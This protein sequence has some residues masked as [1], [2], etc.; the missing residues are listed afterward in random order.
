[1]RMPNRRKKSFRKSALLVSRQPRKLRLQPQPPRQ[2][3]RSLV[4]KH[5]AFLCAG[6]NAGPAK[7]QKAREQGTVILT[8]EDFEHLLENGE[9]RGA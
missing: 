3:L 4:Q 8:R 2:G 9:V 5:L 7:R 1:M 6:E